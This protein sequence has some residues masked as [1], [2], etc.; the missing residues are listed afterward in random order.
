MADFPLGLAGNDFG[1]TF[2]TQNVFGLGSNSTI[3]N[4]LVS[5][6]KIASRSWSWWWGQTGATDEAQMDGSIVFGGYDKAKTL[7][8]P[9]SYEFGAFALDCQSGMHVTITDLVLTFP[10][11]STTSILYPN[12]LSGCLQPDFPPLMTLPNA[13]YFENFERFTQTRNIGRGGGNGIGARGMLYQP[14]E[15]YDG[16]SPRRRILK[17]D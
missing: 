16:R 4:T 8:E 13:P 7:E 14:D 11:G 10:N 12:Q 15:V 5:M 17:A 6:E 2:N 1:G 9:H 3:L